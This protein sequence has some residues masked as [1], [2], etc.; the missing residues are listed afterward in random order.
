M[1]VVCS[2]VFTPESMTFCL[3]FF[4]NRKKECLLS[5]NYERLDDILMGY[6]NTLVPPKEDYDES[7]LI[8]S[9]STPFS[10]S[11][12]LPS[13]RKNSSVFNTVQPLSIPQTALENPSSTSWGEA[14]S[15]SF[16]PPLPSLR[17]SQ[18]KTLSASQRPLSTLPEKL[19]P[20]L[21]K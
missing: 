6:S 8:A 2:D 7:P 17:P 3:N 21:L 4:R 15:M 16:S 12:S 20:N 11:S 14:T 18:L 9:T 13:S 1:F 10:G 5:E 19:Q